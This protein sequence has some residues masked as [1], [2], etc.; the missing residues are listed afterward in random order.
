METITTPK[1][2]ST[3]G[4]RAITT[5]RKEEE[6][7][8]KHD[9][10]N[11]AVMYLANPKK[12]NLAHYCN[13]FNVESKKV[14]KKRDLVA[15]TRENEPETFDHFLKI[16][17]NRYNQLIFPKFKPITPAEMEDYPEVVPEAVWEYAKYL[18]KR[19]YSHSDVANMVSSMG[20]CVQ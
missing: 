7:Q 2:Y 8:T 5:V 17:Q 11:A 6:R 1:R 14:R 13:I 3:R 4:K 19:G 15:Q 20:V 9:T 18:H 12:G 16:A 10:T